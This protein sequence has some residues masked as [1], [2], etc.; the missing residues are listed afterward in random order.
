MLTQYTP[1][2][3]FLVVKCSVIRVCVLLVNYLFICFSLSF[4]TYTIPMCLCIEATVG[5][6]IVKYT[7]DV[8]Q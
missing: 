3:F 8:L 6:C 4:V 7:L 1:V 5:D 2:E